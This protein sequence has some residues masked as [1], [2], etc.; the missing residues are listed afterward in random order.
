[1]T[2]TGLR[3]AAPRGPH[4]PQGC[5]A[6]GSLQLVCMPE[7]AGEGSGVLHTEPHLLL[8]MLLRRLFA[9]A[10]RLTALLFAR[11]PLPQF[12]SCCASGP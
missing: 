1:M 6:F 9:F 7:S 11:R 2:A 4:S 12:S 3:C 8:N 10:R 5:K